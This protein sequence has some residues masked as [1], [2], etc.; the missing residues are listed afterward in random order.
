LELELRVP[1]V[2]ESIEELAPPLLQVG[3]PEGGP[4]T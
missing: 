4:H 2:V 3:H 1:L